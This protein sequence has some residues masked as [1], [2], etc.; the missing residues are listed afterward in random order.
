LFGLAALAYAY[1]IWPSWA[2]L[3]ALPVKQAILA[4]VLPFTAIGF[5]VFL[6]GLGIRVLRGAFLVKDR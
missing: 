4:A 5:G 3:Q 2:K 1:V 6:V